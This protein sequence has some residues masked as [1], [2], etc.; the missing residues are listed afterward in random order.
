MQDFL[1]DWRT[2][3]VAGTAPVAEPHGLENGC[4]PFA[5][6]RTRGGRPARLAPKARRDA[7]AHH[8]ALSRRRQQLQRRACRPVRRRVRAVDRGDREPRRAPSCQ[9]ISRRSA[10]RRSSVLAHGSPRTTISP[11]PVRCSSWR[12]ACRRTIWSTSREPRARRICRPFRRAATLGEAVTDELVRRGDR[13]VARR[14]ADNRGARISETGFSG[15]V[16]RAEDDGI[17]AEKVGLRSGYSRADV[18]R[19]ADQRRRRSCTGACSRRQR[20]KCGPKSARC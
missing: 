17:L 13:E 3:L 12:R 11:S 19:L 8:R 7:A 15:L 5:D 10:T 16:K 18:P 2:I 14:V 4:Q 9:A 1:Q 6:P 20:L